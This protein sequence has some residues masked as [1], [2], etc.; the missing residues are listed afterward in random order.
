MAKIKVLLMGT[1]SEKDSI[2]IDPQN[3][4]DTHRCPDKLGLQS[5][6]KTQPPPVF[7][8]ILCGAELAGMGLI[9]MGQT[10]RMLSPAAHIFYIA[11]GISISDKK[12]LL[13]NGFTNTF[14]LLEEESVFK[15][16]LNRALAE[17]EAALY[18]PIRLI[19]VQVG[20]RINF[21]I[22][23]YLPR[24]NRFV[25]YIGAGDIFDFNRL[26]KLKMF[27][28]NSL[29]VP[30]ADVQKFREYSALRL[31]DLASDQSSSANP[32]KE[33]K[34]KASV[35]E[36]LLGLVHESTRKILNP[37]RKNIEHVRKIVEQYLSL[38]YPGDWQKQIRTIALASGDIFDHARNVAAYAVLFSMALKLGDQ[39]T[40]ATAG[41][42]HDLGLSYLP[43]KL[44][45]T[46]V[47]KMSMDEFK[48]YKTHPTL[49]IKLLQEKNLDVT[50]LCRDVIQHHHVRWDGGGFPTDVNGNKPSVDIQILSLANRFDELTCSKAS[51]NFS[52]LDAIMDRIELENIADPKLTKNLREIILNSESI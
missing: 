17:A 19:D 32:E 51:E 37:D 20:T 25:P 3:E 10:L 41:M 35:K 1:F 38:K 48:L 46:P 30:V 23:I 6:M 39:R 2:T 43:Q 49:S 9:E 29:F 36:L 16:F 40:L 8:V 4:L 15:G 45:T 52:L 28:V 12:N 27:Q 42:L 31:F 33:F 18:A 34:L 7:Q 21:E 14:S 50:D 44:K 24:N 11:E 47:E 26:T 13:K 22:R 5:L